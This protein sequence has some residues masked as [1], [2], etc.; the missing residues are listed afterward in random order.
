MC[1][2][3]MGGECE[4]LRVG[5][6]KETKLEVTKRGLEDDIVIIVLRMGED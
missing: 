3:K 2:C 4:R 5:R 1:V 6:N